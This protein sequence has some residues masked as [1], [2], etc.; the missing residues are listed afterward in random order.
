MSQLERNSAVSSR[1]KNA[2]L[3]T[4]SPILPILGSLNSPEE[5]GMSHT[6]R[7]FAVLSLQIR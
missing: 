6:T 4:L 5:Q 1:V 2:F 3:F 7:T